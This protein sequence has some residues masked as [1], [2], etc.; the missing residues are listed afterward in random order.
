[1]NNIIQKPWGS[2]E[3]IEQN[4]FY[5]VKR[6]VMH[7]GK[8]CSYQYHNEKIETIYVVKGQLRVIIKDFPTVLIPNSYITIANKMPHR[9]EAITDCIY[10]ES[11]T[12]Q[13]DDVVRLEDDY[14][15]IE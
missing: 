7:K 14:G 13:L 6:L 5:L 12:P 1:M 10:L 11:S 4:E 9:M 8:R 3:I 2:E 15:R